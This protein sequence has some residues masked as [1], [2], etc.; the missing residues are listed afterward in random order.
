MYIYTIVNC[1][2]NINYNDHGF[3]MKGAMY[4]TR[5]FDKPGGGKK[6]TQ[7]PPIPSLYLDL[8][9]QGASWKQPS[10]SDYPIPP[11]IPELDA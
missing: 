2:Y 1:Q 3:N 7:P 5:V 4:F 9:E 11:E 10:A 6:K 8:L